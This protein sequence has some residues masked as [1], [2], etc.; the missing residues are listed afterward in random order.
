MF[1]KLVILLAAASTI[2]VAAPT[3]ESHDTEIPLCAPELY[4]KGAKDTNPDNLCGDW[5]LGPAQLPDPN[6]FN[7]TAGYNPFPGLCPSA[8]LFSW[9]NDTAPRPGFIYPQQDGFLIYKNNQTDKT[10]LILDVGLEID[11][12]GGENGTFLAPYLS[13][14]SERALP[15]SNLATTDPKFPFNYHAYRV[16]KPLSV[17]AGTI[18]P[19]FGQEGGG[20][21]YKTAQTVYQL[22]ELGFLEEFA[23]QVV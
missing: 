6:V 3:P 23:V 7:V 1:Q 22:K 13:P 11:R 20:I 4:C 12:F 15:P 21:Q 2:V 8:F 14:Y 19:W 17:E 16:T 18:A 10:T 9:Y 5:R